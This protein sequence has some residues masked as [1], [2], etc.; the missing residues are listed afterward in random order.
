MTS[1]SDTVQGDVT[2]AIVDRSPGA[3]CS[4]SQNVSECRRGLLSYA[5]STVISKTL[6]VDYCPTY[7]VQL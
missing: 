6:I 4:V 5:H 3:A 7:I 1:L 2:S